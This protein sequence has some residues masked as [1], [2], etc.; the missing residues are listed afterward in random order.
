VVSG[1]RQTGKTTLVRQ[2]LKV[3]QRRHHFVAVDERQPSRTDWPADE[4]FRAAGTDSSIRLDEMDRD[5]EWLVRTWARARAEAVS[6]EDGV[7]LVLDEIQKVPGWSETVKGLWDADRAADVP[8]PVVLLGSAPFLMQRGLSESLAGRFELIRVTHWSFEEMRDAFGLTLDEY[9]YYGGYPGPIHDRTEQPRW[10]AVIRDSLIAPHLERDVLSMAEVRK[11][12]LLRRAFELGCECSGQILSYTKMVGQLQD[13][14]N[15]TT[16]AHYIDLLANVGLLVGLPRYAATN[17]R[18]RRSTP[19][20]NVL[21]TALMTAL[22]GYSFEEARTDRHFWARLIESAVG[23]HL[24]NTGTP[25]ARVCYWNEGNREVDFVVEYHRRVIG[26]EVKSRKGKNLRGR[27]AFAERFQVE[28][29]LLVGDD[30]IPLDMFLL[31]PAASWFE[32]R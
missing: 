11:P 29:C 27:Q 17:E 1:P 4:L 14:G 15:T 2:A 24:H 21:N 32:T 30:G 16:I 8:M 22:S 20:L 25:E 26:I 12:A 7:I 18:V 10:R 6:A 5:P 31:A 23:A 3:A 13:A 9:L 28:R 19:K